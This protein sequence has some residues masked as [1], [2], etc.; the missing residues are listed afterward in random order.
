MFVTSG[1]QI[2]DG[3]GHVLTEDEIVS[4]LVVGT[5]VKVYSVMENR[6]NKI[7]VKI[8]ASNSHVFDGTHVDSRGNTIL[9]KFQRKHVV[10]IPFR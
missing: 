6:L 5:W 1:I 4:K 10:E 3:I 8:V 9:I 7:Y 2:T